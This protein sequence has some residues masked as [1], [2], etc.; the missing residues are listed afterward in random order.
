MKKDYI[1]QIE[2]HSVLNI[3]NNIDKGLIVLPQIERSYVWT[4]YQMKDLIES[5]YKDLPVGLIILK[6]INNPKDSKLINQ[7]NIHK[8]LVVDG[9]E[10]LNALYSVF[11]G[12]N[13]Y[14]YKLHKPMISFNPIS[15][16]FEC[17]NSEIENNPFWINN[18]SK[19]FK[20]NIYNFT[21][22]YMNTLSNLNLN[23]N[24]TNVQLNI[25]SLYELGEN[26][27]NII[28]LSKD[29]KSI[30][31]VASINYQK[32]NL[33]IEDY[34]F[35]FLSIFWNEGKL[36]IEDFI[37]G[38]HEPND[39]VKSYNVIEAQPDRIDLLKSILAYSFF[40]G[41]LN[42]SYSIVNDIVNESKENNSF[43]IDKFKEGVGTVCNPVFWQ[44]YVNLISNIGYVSY[45]RLI[46]NSDTLFYTTYALYLLGRKKF[47]ISLN[48]L[49]SV[50]K[51]WFVFCLLTKRHASSYP[52]NTSDKDLRLLENCDDFKETFENIMSKE[53]TPEF[54]RD[55][56]PELL[57][58]PQFSYA[59][60]VYQASTIYNDENALFT[61][62][63][64]KDYFKPVNLCEKQ[65]DQ[66][67]IFPKNYL[68]GKNLKQYQYNQVANFIYIDQRTNIVIKDKPPLEYWPLVLDT[69][70]NTSDRD[71]VLNNYTSVYDLPEKFW[72][73]DYDTFLLE[74]RK[75]MADSIHEYFNQL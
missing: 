69:R 40:H 72:E 4:D 57:T 22:E 36:L 55:K 28:I 31:E 46:L 63:K 45:N 6:H 75:L 15:E 38:S 39:T 32:N 29:D 13:L 9:Q 50:I 16:E 11:K 49:N 37:K 66:H 70:L 17:L 23:Y 73:M 65:L 12:E 64:L 34:I 60:L 52:Q 5:L 24:K 2:E 27:L 33:S 30:K 21:E 19:V 1:Y 71:F 58:A 41:K 25:N 56:L 54:W 48:D 14:N 42:Y 61:H 44:E 51:R 47:N 68:K 26:L 43:T 62:I 7:N 59:Y 67:H 8:Y 53:L 35:S 10:R 18:I 20:N 3:V 74:R